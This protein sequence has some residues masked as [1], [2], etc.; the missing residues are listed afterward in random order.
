MEE[1][2]KAEVVVIMASCPSWREPLIVDRLSPVLFTEC[3][4]HFVAGGEHGHQ[5]SP[6][7]IAVR[8]HRP[9]D[10]GIHHM[11]QALSSLFNGPSHPLIP[12]L[13]AEHR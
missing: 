10:K 1:R 6:Q 4:P 3:L 9:Q 11:L 7:Q 5:L 12:G 8:R 13:H 2:P